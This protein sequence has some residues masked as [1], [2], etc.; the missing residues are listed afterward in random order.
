MNLV[1]LFEWIEATR[2][3]AALRDSYWLF[4]AV[5]S[6]HLLGLCVIG[7]AILIVN[8]RLL[9][10]GL[11]TQSAVQINRDVRPFMIWSLAVMLTSGYLL[12]ASEAT[13]CYTHGAFWVKMACLALAIT[14]TFT[15]QNRAVEIEDRQA[16][17]TQAKL[18]AITTVLLWTGVGIAGRWIGFS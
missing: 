18:T 16:G 14:F 3:G 17:T 2:A 15:L 7:G 6:I 5:E 10:L 11:R 1:P 8:M 13:K 12:F 9:G 4:P